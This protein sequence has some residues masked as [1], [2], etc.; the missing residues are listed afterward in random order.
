MRKITLLLCGLLVGLFASAGV[1][2]ESGQKYRIVCMQYLN[3]CAVLGAGHSAVPAVYYMHSVTDIPED[4][5]WT[6]TLDGA[7]YTLRNAQSGEYLY[8]DPDRRQNSDGAYITKGLDLADNVEGDEA[9][10]TFSENGQGSLII[11]NVGTPGQYF[12]QRTDGTYL[13]GTYGSASTSN[14]FFLLYDEDGHSVITSDENPGGGDMTGGYGTDIYGNYWENTGLEE[15]V[16]YT[17]NVAAPV[18]YSIWNV[19]SG[20][21][22]SVSDKELWQQESADSKFYFVRDASTGGVQVFSENG[23]CVSTSFYRASN[24]N[25][26]LSL[27]SGVENGRNLW[28]ISYN[29]ETGL[30]GYTLCKKD[31]LSDMNW[32]QSSYLYWNDYSLPGGHGVGLYDVDEGS[33]FVFAS[34]DERHLEWLQENGIDAGGGTGRPTS[35]KSYLTHLK[36]GGREL[37]YDKTSKEYFC[38][39]PDTLRTVDVYNTTVEAAFKTT[40]GTYKLLLDGEEADG[41]FTMDSPDCQSTYV[42]TITKDGEEVAEANLHFTYLPIVE[43]T[44]PGCNGSTYTTGTIRVNDPDFEGYVDTDVAAFRYRGATAQSYPKKSYAVKLRDADGNSIDREYFGLRNDNNW[45]LDA[46]AIDKACMRNRV[47]TDL[48]NDFSKKPYQRREGWEPKAKSGT[49]GRF[50]ELF[51]NGTYHGLYC[52]TE[53]MD[54]KQLRLKKFVPATETSEDTIH[55]TLYKSAQWSYEVFMGHELDSKYF[56]KR[57]PRSYN[58][59]TWSET[60]ASYEVKYPDWEDEKIDWGPLWNAINFVATSSDE[61]FDDLVD[62]WFDFP[63]LIDYYLFIETMLASDN[64]GKNMFFFNYDILGEKNARMIGIAPWDLDGTWGARWNGSETITKPNLDFDTFL[65]DHEHG[66]HT[67][68][69]RLQRSNR[70]KWD[71]LLAERYAELRAGEFSAKNLT[72][73]FTDYRDLFVESGAAGREQGKW[74]SLH[75]NISSDVDYICNWIEERLAYLDKEYGYTPVPDGIGNVAADDSPVS[76]MGGKGY[77]LIHSRK[78]GTANLYTVGGVLVKTVSLDQPMTRVEGLAPGIYVVKGKKAIV[79]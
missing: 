35:F 78:P 33:V 7:G 64:H 30:S 13:L 67:L 17:E 46:M 12:N 73:R 65:W 54:R 69:Y 79:R 48:W 63:V 20:L 49:R 45:I 47:S 40:D 8:Y 4:G 68:F 57:A 62:T 11:E 61:E 66:T 1:K 59:N 44:M 53:K 58:N 21:Y 9:R 60:W 23:L 26:P 51:L 52:M 38:S 39:L 24:G 2:V 19:R 6:V 34:S 43:A 16:V 55:G 5:W 22:A 3:G 70:W 42:M 77:L 74:S 72:K 50:V 18:L 37:T 76:I 32:S 36:I 29:Q 71:N 10:W 75:R 14:C 27:E 25:S 41:A 56:P 31:N 28:S 15:P